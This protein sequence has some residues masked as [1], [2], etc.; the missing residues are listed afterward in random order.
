M[1]PIAVILNPH[2]RKNRGT[3]AK[4]AAVLRDVLGHWGTVHETHALTDLRR[5]VGDALDR[6]VDYLVAD[7]GDGC[8]HWVLNEARQLVSPSSLQDLPPVVPTRSG[9][10]DFMAHKV[11]LVG[12]PTSILRSL[13]AHMEDGGAPEI[14]HVDSLHVGGLVEKGG[15]LQHFDRLGFAMAAGGIGQRFFRKYYEEQALGAG[16]ILRVV[17]K[18]VGSRVAQSLPAFSSRYGSY[19]EEIFSRTHARVSVDGRAVPDELHGAIH[20]GA[21]DISLAGL[22][23]VFPLA[24]QEGVIHFQ[25]GAITA[26]EVIG[27]LPALCQGKTIPSRRLV[28]VGGSEMRIDALGEEL[29]S[30][31]LDGEIFENIRSLHVRRGPRVA[32]ACVQADPSKVN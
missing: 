13:V 21:F 14:K 6:G 10:I 23:R 1:Q 26:T 19:A 27:A 3:S 15:K 16:A 20:A 25:A 18:A 4:R 32:V 28:E 17:A 11:G 31:V 2:A 29:L 24:S 9:T 5:V 30:P 12:T 22:F 8:L 7:G